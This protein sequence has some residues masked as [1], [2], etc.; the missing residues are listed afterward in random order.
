MPETRPSICRFC[1]AHCGILVETEAGRVLDVAGDRD[2]PLYRG[3]L[4]PKGRALPEQHAHPRRLLHSVRR[5]PDGVHAPVPHQQAIGEIAAKLRELLDRHGPRSIA[6]YVGTYSF[7]YPAAAPMA[8]AWMNAIDSPMRFM[9]ATIDKPGKAIA[10]AL[11]G[12]WAAGAQTFAS[13]DTWM[14]IGANPIV[15]KSIGAP[16]HNPSRQLHDAVRRGMRLIVLDPRRTEAARLATVHLQG[17]PGEDP[18]VIAGLLHVILREGWLDRQFVTANAQGLEA[19]RAAVEPFSPEYVQRRADVSRE[20]LVRAARIFAEGPRG[21]AVAGTG[22]NMAPRGTLAEYLLL[23]LNTVCGRWLRAG[24]RLPNPGALAP[25][26]SPRAQAVAPVPGWGFG[27]RLRVRGLTNT[28]AG[29]PSA[30]LADEILLEGPG[31]V[32]ALICVGGNP[33]AAW[34]DQLRT[35]AAM[36]RLE[37]LVTIDPEMSATAKLA[38]YVIAP[39]LSLEQPGITLAV[40][41]LSAYAYGMGYDSPYAQYA[42]KL[43]DP[44]AGSDVI[45]EWEFFFELARR[46]DLALSLEPA[47]PWISDGSRAA[48]I[49]LDMQRAPSTDELLEFLTR[50]SRVPLAEVKAHPHGHVFDDVAVAVQPKDPSCTARLELAHPVMLAE[51]EAAAQE[52]A[53]ACTGFAFR[54]IPRRLPD[55]YNSAGRSIPRLVR[56]YPYNPAFAHPEDLRALGVAPGEVIEIRSSHGA[57]LGVVEADAG[58]R[59]GVISMT[60]AFGD[61]PDAPEAEQLRRVGSNTGLLIPVDRDFDPY[62]GIPRMSAIPVSVCRYPGPVSD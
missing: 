41:T 53:D 42:P 40:E 18:A 39:R 2:N 38:H 44:P 8:M 47:L 61:V 15:S 28:V 3:Y 56:K 32:K 4:C 10:M 33:L 35:H 6:L 14:I 7:M 36:K 27:E 37:L 1:A 29:L 26:L 51:L 46:M 45:E 48:P 22:P 57:I 58:L 5:G 9:P 20:L 19:L 54:L 55:V 59:R 50:G 23:C 60:H 30:A 31:Q 11:H 17:R 62:S 21:F 24:E 52:A 49:A 25:A 12:R 34:P 16:P 13:A 43:V